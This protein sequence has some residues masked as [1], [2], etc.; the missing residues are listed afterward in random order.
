MTEDDFVARLLLL[1]AHK[2]TTSGSIVARYCFASRMAPFVHIGTQIW[3][4][5]RATVR[6]GSFAYVGGDFA[7]ALK[8]IIHDLEALHDETCNS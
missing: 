1:G 7:L 2:L 8:I 6:T 3:V 5:T 4:D